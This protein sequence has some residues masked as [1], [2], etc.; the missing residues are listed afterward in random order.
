MQLEPG[1]LARDVALAAKQVDAWKEEKMCIQ[2]KYRVVRIIQRFRE[3][4]HELE[5]KLRRSRNDKLK[6]SYRAAIATLDWSIQELQM[7]I[8]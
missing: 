8:R 2:P 4:K 1:W 6:L 5:T 3:Q 7:A